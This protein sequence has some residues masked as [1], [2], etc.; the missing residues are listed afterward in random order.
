MN[1]EKKYFGFPFTFWIVILFEFVERG[2][3]YGMMSILTV[4]MTEQLGF[5]KA[6]VGTIKSTIQPLLYILPIL[7][8]AIA[9]KMGYRKT[10]MVAFGLLGIGYSLT[11]FT[12]EYT[13]VFLSLIILAFGAGTFKPIISGTIAKVT[14]ESNSGFAFGVFYWTINLG[15][16]LFPLII[17]PYLKSINQSLVM[18]VSGIL[19]ASMIIPT[20]FIYRE[21]AREDRVKES[22]KDVLKSILNK[23]L[24]ILFDWRFILFIFIYSWFWVL[25]F[26]MFDTVLWYLKDFV[27]ATPLNNFV[28]NTFGFNWKFDVEH[29]TVI[30]AFAIILLQFLISFLVK[31]AKALPTMIIGISIATIGMGILSLSTSIW[32]FLAGIFIFSIGEMTAHPKF[33]SYLGLIAAPEK[34]ATYMGFGFLYGF[35]GSFMAGHLGAYLYVQFIDKPMIIYVREKLAE[36]GQIL[37]SDVTIKE[38]INAAEKLGISKAQVAAHAY[39]SELWMIFSLIGVLCIVGL[40]TYQYL[41][42]KKKL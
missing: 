24:N 19:T 6:A 8:G 2:S 33:I 35:F 26:Q 29:V 30:N 32:V 34:K 23:I 7:T 36:T 11:S 15:A 41:F 10:L 39:P 20:F 17:V 4:Y 42:V 18:L 31:K 28:S 40:I 12:S 27:D 22:F 9:D 25:Y 16:F 21:P 3:Y 14:D 1:T 37:N 38:A 5:S 13:A